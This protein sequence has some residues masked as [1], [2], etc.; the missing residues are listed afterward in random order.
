MPVIKKIIKYIINGILG[1]FNFTITRIKSNTSDDLLSGLEEKKRGG[2]DEKPFKTYYPTKELFLKQYRDSKLNRV[3]IIVRLLAIEEYYGKNDY[4]FDLYL[5]MQNHR[6]PGGEKGKPNTIDRVLRLIKSI[7]LNSFSDDDPVRV[8]NNYELFNGSHRVA[9]A[10]FF[11]IDYIPIE[12]LTNNKDITFGYDFFAN[13]FSV[14]EIEIIREKEGEI[15]KNSL[16]YNKFIDKIQRIFSSGEQSFGRGIFYQSFERFQIKGQR[17]TKFRFFVYG[18][19]QFLKKEHEVLDIGCNCGFFSLYTSEY[20]KCIDGVE[21]NQVLIDIA[22]E[23]KNYLDVKN[24]NFYCADF[25]QFSVSKR[26]D[27]IFSFAVH[28]WI[29]MPMEKYSL[30]LESMLNPG[31]LVVF[32]SQ[33]IESL[34]KDFDEKVSEFCRDKFK[35]IKSGEI[36]DD[37]IILR[38]YK[39]LMLI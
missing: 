8:M 3:D 21:F 27:V 23:T 5:R 16:R 36:M 11:D 29:G 22:N 10:L 19:D 38:N 39:I 30:K 1:K 6:M 13:I 35:I 17:P 28:H 2:Y 20:V 7:E 26:Y 34:D 37:K 12:V 14:K 9:T 4:G 25:N 33:N 32:E 31:G 15:F 24:C 18:L